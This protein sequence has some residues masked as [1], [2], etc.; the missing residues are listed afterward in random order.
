MDKL[1]FP[2]NLH[3]Y[4]IKNSIGINQGRVIAIA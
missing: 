4:G 3:I 2:I 1:V